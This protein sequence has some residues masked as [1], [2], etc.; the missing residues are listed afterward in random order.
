MPRRPATPDERA[1]QRSR[2]RRAAAEVHDEK[3]LLGVTVRAVSQRAGVSSGTI[4]TYFSS[5]EEILQSLWIDPVARAS[6]RLESIAA[7]HADP[8]EGIRALLTA[9]VDFA[10]D[11]PEVFRGAL[12][13]VRPDS[14]AT[15]TP[16]PVEDLTFYRLL[17]AAIE[18]GQAAGAVRLGSSDRIAHLA[19]ASIHGALALP[20]NIHRFDVEPQEELAAAMVDHVLESLRPSPATRG[21]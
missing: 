9:Y 14:M 19:W 20:I 12:L 1:A 21:T 7:K 18:H 5:L 15:P 11:E 3:G 2:I 6:R 8:I 13:F 10:L 17:R 16:D 4:Y